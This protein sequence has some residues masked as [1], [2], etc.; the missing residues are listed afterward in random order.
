MLWPNVLKLYTS[1]IPAFSFTFIKNDI[2]KIANMNITRK[3][4]RHILNKA[5]RDIAK[6]N[7]RVLI[8]FAPFTKRRTR[9]IFATRTTRSNV[10]DT[11]NFSIMSL[12]T[13]STNLCLKLIVYKNKIIY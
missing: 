3:S 13:K 1:S 7:N 6:A 8:P 5:G 4:R 2:P 9:P 12:S 11:K 10:G